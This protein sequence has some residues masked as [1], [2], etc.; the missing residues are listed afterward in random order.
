VT[1]SG[2]ESST[3]SENEISNPRL[4]HVDLEITRECNLKCVH[5]SSGADTKGHELSLTEEKELLLEAK[6]LGLEAVGLTGGEPFL[7]FD[8]LTRLV[9][10]CQDEI[11]VSVHIHSNGTRIFREEARWLKE[12]GVN[13]SLSIFGSRPETHDAI[14]N[15]AGSMKS[16]LQGLRNLV[17]AKASLTAFVVPMRSNLTEI[18]S[19]IEMVRMEGVEDVRILLPSPT[20]RAFQRFT[21]IELS[22]AQLIWLRKE[23]ARFQEKGDVHLSAGFCTR[24]ALPDLE[25]LRGHDLCYAAKNRV[26]VDAFGNVYSCT[27][28]SGRRIFSAGNISACPLAEIWRVS[29]SF[30][31]LRRFH[32]DRVKKCQA[33]LRFP[34]CMSG[35]RVRMS[36]AYGDMTVADPQCGGPYF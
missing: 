36:Y 35:C 20:G 34:K 27:A 33:C 21:E 5:C 31:F 2:Y 19:L 18:P 16:T 9:D 17:K 28:S 12:S 1:T 8:K 3:S 6:S 15:V 13:I 30:Q 7:R 29:P 25:T 32:R 14:T 4:K 24:L 10:F 23:L 22:T 11:R 26:H